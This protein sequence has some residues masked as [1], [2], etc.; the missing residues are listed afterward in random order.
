M[1]IFRSFYFI[2]SEKNNKLKKKLSVKFSYIY[3]Y[4]QKKNC[5]FYKKNL[6]ECKVI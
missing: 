6:N 3:V 2:Y 5:F 4:E 1:Y